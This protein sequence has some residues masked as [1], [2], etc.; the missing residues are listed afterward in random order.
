MHGEISSRI[1]TSYPLILII[2]MSLLFWT[3]VWMNASGMPS[4]A[5][6][7]SSSISTMHVSSTDSLETVGELAYSLEEKS[8]YLL[9]PA[10]V[11]TLM[12]PYIFSFRNICDYSV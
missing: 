2:S 12:V 5:T 3:R 1:S 4:T 11:L 7:M 8:P 9:P 6:S 10:T